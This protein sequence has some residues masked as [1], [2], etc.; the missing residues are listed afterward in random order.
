MI[1]DTVGVA[2]EF[3][4]FA[5]AALTQTDTQFFENSDANL[6]CLVCFLRK[7]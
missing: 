5:A 2:V 7:S 3:A 6:Y 4:L 1:V